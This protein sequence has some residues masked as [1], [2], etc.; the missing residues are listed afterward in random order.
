[1][2][3]AVVAAHKIDERGV[4]IVDISDPANP[5][6]TSNVHGPNFA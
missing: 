4:Q 3:Y 1:M 6:I 5:S 2:T